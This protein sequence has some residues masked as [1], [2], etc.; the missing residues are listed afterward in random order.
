ME[1]MKLM[2]QWMIAAILTSGL[3]LT[4][5]KDEIDNPV[6]PTPSG[7]EAVDNGEW[8]IS[9]ANMDQAVAP[10]DNFFM[11]CNGSW[12]KNTQLDGKSHDGYLHEATGWWQLRLTMCDLPSQDKL[13]ADIER[14]DQTSAAAAALYQKTLDDSGLLT[15]TTKEEAWRA[16]GR[17]VAA[18]M[19]TFVS[20]GV[21]FVKGK[22]HLFLELAEPEVPVSNGD[23]DADLD[24][25]SLS[26]LMKTHP[27]V[28]ALLA[29]I[30]GGQT[31]RSLQTGGQWPMLVAMAEGMG[32]DPSS[33]YSMEDVASR[34]VTVKDEEA[35]EKLRLML[36]VLNKFQEM[37]VASFVQ[38]LR[39]GYLSIDSAY[40]STD[41][42]SKTVQSL[43]NESGFEDYMED[44]GGGF[45][46]GYNAGQPT[47]QITKNSIA[48]FFSNKYLDY[49]R[50]KAVADLVVTP[51]VKA[52]GL[53]L[54]E[55]LRRAF[56]QRIK[57]NTWL[58][59]AS[60]QRALEKLD[61]MV[62]NVGCPDSW[63]EEGLPDLSQCGSLLED[64][65]ALRRA[66]LSLFKR[67]QG[68]DRTEASFHV[69]I[70]DENNS[71]DIVNA[72]YTWN[73]NSMNIY[74]FWLVAPIYREANNKAITYGRIMSW[75]HEL[76]HGFDNIGTQYN[77]LGDKE[78]L[79]ANEADAQAFK[80]RAAELARQ[81]CSY[82]VLPEELP[83]IKANGELTVTEDIA[84]LGGL[85]T[86]YQAYCNRLEADGFR[87]QSLREQQKR[88]FLAFADLW[89]SK[90][91]NDHVMEAL[92]GIGSSDGKPD[93]HSLDRERVNGT[94]TNCDDWYDLFDVKPGQKL[95]RSP[96]ERVYIW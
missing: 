66:R 4:S 14:I 32:L 21:I 60:K 85:L 82:D 77:K 24:D 6:S 11:Y 71:L 41:A 63:I 67:L 5:C 88:F 94:V 95:Y 52:N 76:T 16:A 91:N 34:L 49:E 55:E 1:S 9:A 51:E 7:Q 58:S 53:A 54:C 62:L 33:V 92:Y 48:T 44:F 73:T 38:N 22:A 61:A 40:V 93:E 13:T 57:T 18:G 65:F 3:V 30:T 74:P 10:G 84:D 64:V 12:W 79:F 68:M 2:K 19:K 26:G 35:Q 80:A 42:I 75:A 8:T 37:D 46:Y 72:F 25:L 83:G 36:M 86:A 69:T 59:E 28:K 31:T 89:R 90:Y 96:A 43:N 81:Y 78:Q 50:S 20:P 15:A 56:A 47:K 23:D 87:G 45:D 70:V 39:E 29:P 17:L 27:E